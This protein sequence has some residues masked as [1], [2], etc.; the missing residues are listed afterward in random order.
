MRI[1][2]GATTSAPKTT[3]AFLARSAFTSA[4]TS[5]APSAARSAVTCPPTLP[6]PCT[7][8]RV[9]AS[10]LRSVAAT[11]ARMDATTPLAVYSEGSRS[12]LDTVVTTVAT[13]SR[14]ATEVPMSTAGMYLPSRD[15]MRLACARR[16]SSRFAALGEA[17]MTLFPPPKST[18]A[19]AALNVI[20]RAK[21]FASS[22][23]AALSG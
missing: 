13:R 18:P 8:I 22:V 14:S 9:S 4:T 1:A 10:D 6:S 7:A 15:S 17:L 19:S 11:A 21:R 3:A 16:T 12:L 5:R 20:A 2:D 23:A